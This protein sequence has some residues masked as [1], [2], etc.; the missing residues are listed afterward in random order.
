MS[1]IRKLPIL[2]KRW[3][4]EVC[5]FYNI[6]EKLARTAAIEAK[7]YNRFPRIQKKR[8]QAIEFLR[9]QFENSTSHK[10][11]ELTDEGKSQ[12]WQNHFMSCIWSERSNRRRIYLLK[13]ILRCITEMKK[14]SN[15]K[16][17]V[18]DF[19]CGTSLFGRLVAERHPDIELL[20][21][22][23]NGFHFRFAAHRTSQFS[24]NVKLFPLNNPL[25]NCQNFGLLDLIYCYTV[26]EHLPNT[27]DVIKYFVTCLKSEGILIETYTGHSKHTPHKGD[28]LC[29]YKQRDANL[30]YL[31]DNLYL[32]YGKLPAKGGDGVY[33][34]DRSVR[35]WIKP[36]FEQ[37]RANTVKRIFANNLNIHL[38]LVRSKSIIDNLKDAIFALSHLI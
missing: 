25:D 21:C 16:L 3:Y 34:E 11:T 33:D 36:P 13:K 6:P 17:C 28:T 7:Y 19:G 12:S 10:N 37:N 23:M 18:L 27:G 38:L 22:D 8:L 35:C 4:S 31:K 26:F 9:S 2:T 5:E 30:D 29:S 24:K 32:L 20:L 14:Y 1:Q 15:S